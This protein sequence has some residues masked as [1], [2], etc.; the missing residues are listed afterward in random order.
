MYNFKIFQKLLILVILLC[1]GMQPARAY[2]TLQEYLLK[3]NL[4]MELV[5]D[6][7]DTL[8]CTLVITDPKTGHSVCTELKTLCVSPKHLLPPANQEDVLKKKLTYSLD[9]KKDDASMNLVE[10]AKKLDAEGKFNNLV[11]SSNRRVNTIS[12]L[13]IWQRIGGKGPTIDGINLKSI[14]KDVLDKVSTTSQIL[15]TRDKLVLRKRID[16]ICEAIDKTRKTA[17]ST[18]VLKTS[19]DLPPTGKKD[20]VLLSSGS[21]LVPCDQDT[22]QNMML[23]EDTYVDVPYL[24]IACNLETKEKSPPPRKEPGDDPNGHED[25]PEKGL[26][27]PTLS[28]PPPQ[29]ETVNCP[30]PDPPIGVLLESRDESYIPE[31]GSST[32]ATAQIY[33]K[34]GE[35]WLKSARTDLLTFQFFKNHVSSE[36][37]ECMNSGTQTSVDLFF[38]QELN[39]AFNCGG[40]EDNH[41]ITATSKEEVNNIKVVLKCEDFAAYSQVEVVGKKAVQLARYGD[42]VTDKIKNPEDVSKTVPADEKPVGDNWENRNHIADAYEKQQNLYPDSKLDNEVIPE[43]DKDKPGDGY[44]AYEEYR[45]FKVIGPEDKTKPHIRTSWIQKDLFYYNPDA[46]DMTNYEKATGIIL[47]RIEDSQFQYDSEIPEKFISVPEEGS[48][49]FINFNHHFSHLVNQHGVSIKYGTLVS[50]IKLTA[51]QEK[52][53]G[54]VGTL[55]KSPRLSIEKGFMG[56][57][58]NHSCIIV[59]KNNVTR[60][61]EINKSDFGDLTAEQAVARY[62]SHEFS[63]ASCLTHHGEFEK[64]ARKKDGEDVLDR[65]GNIVYDIVFGNEK[66]KPGSLIIPKHGLSSGDWDCIMRYKAWKTSVIKK[67]NGDYEAVDTALGA[68]NKLCESPSGTGSNAGDKQSGNAAKGRGDCRHKLNVSDVYEGSRL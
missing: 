41:P 15:S 37:G 29:I 53:F 40:S 64:V 56:P 13:S 62:V 14:E 38:D 20:Q 50:S 11:I 58:K 55:A 7:R 36:P 6:G 25:G 1:S 68:M 39:P 12:Q 27:D 30:D 60:L 19:S 57:P 22:Y 10:A 48:S 24:K 44:S 33:E 2:E 16:S 31:N 52:Q 28:G 5:G 47:H 18:K 45:G 49:I 43:S 42:L 26:G 34:Q 66:E 65:N 67:D 8:K 21:I 9:I 4:K 17:E 51:E 59:D 46:I 32:W 3:H 61:F 23:V 54:T 63:H 35:K